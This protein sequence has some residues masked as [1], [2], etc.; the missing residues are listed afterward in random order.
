MGRKAREVFGSISPELV[1]ALEQATGSGI[2]TIRAEGRVMTGSRGFPIGL[3][4]TVTA[5]D[6][7]AG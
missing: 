2:R 6:E 4:T 7:Q 1:T 3:N 5:S